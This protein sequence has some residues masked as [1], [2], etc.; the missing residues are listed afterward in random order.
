MMHCVY[1][2]VLISDVIAPESCNILFK[3]LTCG[4]LPSSPLDHRDALKG[5]PA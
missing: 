2:C 4:Y 3:S 1:S 5:K